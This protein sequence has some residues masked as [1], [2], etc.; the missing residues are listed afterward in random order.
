MK[1]AYLWDRFKYC[2]K[3]SSRPKRKLDVKPRSTF[4]IDGTVQ[5]HVGAGTISM[6]SPLPSH[7]TIPPSP[8]DA[9]DHVRTFFHPS[10][11]PNITSLNFCVELV[12]SPS[13][14]HMHSFL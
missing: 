9:E 5:S 4:F 13:S 11:P 10:H 12:V 3:K 7:S 8:S 6:D 1:F 2:L 14:S